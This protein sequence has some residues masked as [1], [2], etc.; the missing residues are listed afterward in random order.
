[1]RVNNFTVDIE[2]LHLAKIKN[3]KIERFPVT[4]STKNS[5]TTIKFKDTIIMFFDILKIRFNKNYF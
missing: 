2:I 4:M 3:K 5:V 1:M